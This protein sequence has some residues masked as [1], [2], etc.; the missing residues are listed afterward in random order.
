M[1]KY[2]FVG[3]TNK[4]EQVFIT[5]YDQ[6]NAK[7]TVFVTLEEGKEYELTARQVE[8]LPKLPNG[9]LNPMFVLVP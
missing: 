9:T 5:A 4:N 6:F 2:K 7:D 1:A 8:A 3:P